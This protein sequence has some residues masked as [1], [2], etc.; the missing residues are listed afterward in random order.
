MEDVIAKGGLIH[1]DPWEE[2][3]TQEEL[4]FKRLLKYRWNESMKLLEGGRY[5]KIIDLWS[6]LDNDGYF[7]INHVEWADKPY[8][9]CQIHVAK[10]HLFILHVQLGVHSNSETHMPCACI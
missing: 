6:P 9:R 10:A 8:F 2:A 7:R 3:Q 5:Q 1:M 4:E